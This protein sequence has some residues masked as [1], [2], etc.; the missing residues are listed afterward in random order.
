M[1]MPSFIIIGAARAGTTALHYALQGHDQVF[2]A[3]P[4]EPNFFAVEGGHHGFHWRGTPDLEHSLIAGSVTDLEEYEK[5]FRNVGT[6]TAIGEV[7]PLYLSSPLA[8]KRIHAYAPAAKIIAVLR[9][10]VDRAYSH[11]MQ[12]VRVTGSRLDDYP[13][14]F[15]ATLRS[16]VDQMTKGEPLTHRF[17]VPLVYGGLYGRHLARY[18]DVLPRSQIRLYRY[19]DLDTHPQEL[20]RDLLSFIGVDVTQEVD[21]G[22]RYNFSGI[23]T[24]PPV[25]VVRLPRKAK[26][27]VKR[28]LPGSVVSRIAAVQNRIARRRVEMAP[29]LPAE[30][31]SR[32]FE[33]YFREDAEELAATVDLDL[34]HW[35]S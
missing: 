12:R 3:S 15:A 24:K 17:A 25:D 29:A 6:S 11:F 27:W 7:S 4:K 23:A 1:T 8:A 34:S 9:H 13:N 21:L 18:F 19:C 28:R 33:E 26:L 35:I 10:P 31:R 16:E 2:V 5:L 22:T 20:M 32:L 30:L 14:A